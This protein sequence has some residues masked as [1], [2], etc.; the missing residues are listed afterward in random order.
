M[1]HLIP[2]AAIDALMR[3]PSPTKTQQVA[4]LQNH[5]RDLLGP[6]YHT[7]L[8]GS[9][10]NDTAP[11]DI[12]DVDIVVVRKKTYSGTYSPQPTTS[13][14]AWKT[15]QDELIIKL[16][17]DTSYGWNVERGDKCIKLEGV[18]NAD[19]IPAVVYNDYE[20]DPIVVYS[21][22]EGKEIV[23]HPRVHYE[24]GVAKH[25]VTS[26]RFKPTVRMFKNWKQNHYGQ[27]KDT[28]SSFKIEALVHGADDAHFVGDGAARFILVGENI[29]ERLNL[30]S[31]IPTS[32]MSV[33][34]GEDIT[35]N[36]DLAARRRFID[37]LT[38]SVQ[39]ARQA[40]NAGNQAL[41]EAHWDLAFNQ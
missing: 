4:A 26:K 22:R 18:F 35:A 13:T 16:L 25:D 33:C 27:E 9:Y 10:K 34:G 14:I 1:S 24:N 37:Q 31:L 6:D 7:F 20:E 21:F 28:V 41:A 2:T 8:Q 17:Q 12:N 38:A 36:W 3:G 30:R 39:H 32:I 15:I 40:Y 19:V 11:S 29:L 23:N 5:I